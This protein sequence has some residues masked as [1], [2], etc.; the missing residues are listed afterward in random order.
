MQSCKSWSMASNFLSVAHRGGGCEV[1]ENSLAGILH[2]IGVGCDVVEFDVRATK[3]GVVVL[4]HDE[5]LIRVAGMDRKL[6]EVSFDELQKFQIFH[7]EPF[8]TFDEVLRQTKKRRCFVEVKEPDT[9]AQVMEL[10]F[11]YEAVDRCTIISFFEE[12]LIEAKKIELRIQTGLI[13]YRGKIEVAKEIGADLVL[14]YYKIATKKANDFAH[15]LGLKVG[16]WSVNQRV[17]IE[18]MIAN[19]ADFIASDYPTML[20]GLKGG[21]D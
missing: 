12:A 11:K 7:K 2:G 9:I 10:I 5:D 16:V 17:D 8:V 4:L 19:G 18:K 13:Y 1:A 3:D 15:S 6:A 21:R 20:V 14:P